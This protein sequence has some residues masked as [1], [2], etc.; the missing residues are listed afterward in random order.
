MAEKCGFFDAKLVGTEYDRVYLA[1][2]FASYF[3]SFIGNGVFSQAATNLQ[4][5]SLVTPAMAVNVLPGEGWINGYW[6]KNTD[7]LR[8]NFAVADG[9]FTRIDSI[10]LR[11][12]F[13]SR[14]ISLVVRKG[15]AAAS[16]VSPAVS[17]DTDNY[18]LQ[19]ATVRIA[20]GSTVVK[21][22][23][24]TDTR[25]VK[26]VCGVVTGLIDQIDTTNLFVQYNAAFNAWFDE[27]KGQLSGDT[28]GNL[29]NMINQTNK[30]LTALST[31]VTPV[32]YGGTGA[33]AGPAA[34]NNLGIT[35]GTRPAPATGTPNTIYIQLV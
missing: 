27:A 19:L 22:A 28:A 2:S 16:P 21:Q 33:T 31:R 11:L 3:A 34:L 25:M 29:L 15:T 13:A 24:I 5:V 26:S 23:Q 12:N 4:V 10:V 35:W 8:L 20:P 32:K 6:Y 30:D 1:S 14:L 17:R 7:N 18:E 9:V